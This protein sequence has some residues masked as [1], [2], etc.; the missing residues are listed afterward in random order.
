M[1]AVSSLV[2]V[3]LP[4]YLSDLPLP[5]S[6]GGWFS[7]G[8]TDWLRLVPFGAAVGGLSYLGLRGLAAAPGVG[9]VIQVLKLFSNW[10]PL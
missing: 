7:L 3:T 6:F 2:K 10:S 9:P 8:L 4:R 5:D 1:Q